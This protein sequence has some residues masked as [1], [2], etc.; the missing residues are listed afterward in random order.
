MKVFPKTNEEKPTQNVDSTILKSGVPVVK[1]N[2]TGHQRSS[3][4]V[5]AVSLVI[6]RS[7]HHALP[8]AVRQVNLED[9]F[10]KDF[11]IV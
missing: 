10:V 7:C 9:P 8:Q 5:D 4:T 11:V 2:T 3:L 1:G 6:S